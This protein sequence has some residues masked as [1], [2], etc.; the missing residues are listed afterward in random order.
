MKIKGSFRLVVWEGPGYVKTVVGWSVMAGEWGRLKPHVPQ[1]KGK[2]VQWG[3][4]LPKAQPP[5]LSRL[6][7]P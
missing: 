5:V 4:H 1:A 3:P 6:F 2:E 7:G